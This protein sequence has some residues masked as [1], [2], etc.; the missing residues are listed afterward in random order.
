MYM[1]AKILFSILLYTIFSIQFI[2]SNIFKKILKKLLDLYQWNRPEHELRI[3]TFQFWKRLVWWWPKNT[4][5]CH[6][7]CNVRTF[8]IKLFRYYA[9]EGSRWFFPLHSS[10]SISHPSTCLDI[11]M[12]ESLIS[13]LL[14]CYNEPN[15]DLSSVSAEKRNVYC[16]HGYPSSS[17]G[18]FKHHTQQGGNDRV[19]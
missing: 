12:N 5:L 2:R 16:C 15:M 1:L 17:K 9:W 14:I 6:L 8:N 4:L 18:T 7:W 19:M 13:S 10:V 11:N 3:L